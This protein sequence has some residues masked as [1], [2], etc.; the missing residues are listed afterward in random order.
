MMRIKM[1]QPT[2]MLG[3][4]VKLDLYCKDKKK[5]DRS[6]FA[7]MVKNYSD[8]Y[9]AMTQEQQGQLA[10]DIREHYKEYEWSDNTSRTDRSVQTTDSSTVE[11][12]I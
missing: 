4:F 3:L 9:K 1:K 5:F 8:Q 6:V 7:I 12:E 2:G 11:K 10:M